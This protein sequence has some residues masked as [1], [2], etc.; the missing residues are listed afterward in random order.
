[1]RTPKVFLV[2]ELHKDNKMDI[3]SALGYGQLDYLLPR[4][5][6]PASVDPVRALATMRDRVQDM[7]DG[8]YV[9]DVPGTDPIGTLLLGIA[10]GECCMVDS[11]NWL[12]WDRRTDDTGARTKSGYYTPVVTVIDD[13][14]NV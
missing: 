1:M 5:G 12:R 13:G 8:D 6:P 3:S 7:R 14:G 4:S 2:Q 11:L 9:L 10:I